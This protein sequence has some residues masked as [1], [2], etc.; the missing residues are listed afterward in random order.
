M[1]DDFL[2]TR[3]ILFQVMVD[4]AASLMHTEKTWLF[5]KYFLKATVAFKDSEHPVADVYEG[6][7]SLM[8]RAHFEGKSDKDN[9]RFV[10][11]CQRVPEARRI[12][13]RLENTVTYLSVIGPNN[14]AQLP[15]QYPGS[16]TEEMVLVNPKNCEIFPDET[17][18]ATCQPAFMENCSKRKCIEEKHL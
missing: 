18:I 10:G 14:P 5:M 2:K 7:F 9:H 11:I 17:T 16:C 12:N 4:R 3:T 13:F 1:G 15:K 6:K 8:S